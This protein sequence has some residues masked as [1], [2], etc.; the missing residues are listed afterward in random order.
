[1]SW[2]SA[3]VDALLTQGLSAF[4]DRWERLPLFSS[5]ARLPEEQRAR[6]RQARMGHTAQGLAWALRELGTG[7]MPSLWGRLPGLRRPVTALSG[8]LDEKFSAIAHKIA[9]LAP[10]ARARSIEGAGH[11]AV[12]EAPREIAGEIRRGLGLSTG[13]QDEL[14][15]E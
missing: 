12:L 5:Q 9:L 4:L 2:D 13:V 8:A 3:E 10:G 7:R 14:Y 6:Q 1:A 15:V 11:N